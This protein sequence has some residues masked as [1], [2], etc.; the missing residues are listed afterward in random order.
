MFS[1]QWPEL[2]SKVMILKKKIV[3]CCSEMGF[4][5]EKIRDSLVEISFFG[6]FVL[7]LA[8]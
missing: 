4:L 5:R 6:T 7:L 8:R 2:L 3:I 1:L